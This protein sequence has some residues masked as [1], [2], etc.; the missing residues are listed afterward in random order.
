VGHVARMEDEKC[1]QK[2]DEKL[3]NRPRG[4]PRRKWWILWERS[5]VKRTE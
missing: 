2:F 4:N 5:D 3:K 1:A